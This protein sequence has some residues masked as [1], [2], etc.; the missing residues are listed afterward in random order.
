MQERRRLQ[1]FRLL[2]RRKSLRQ[3]ISDSLHERSA[4]LLVSS[5]KRLLINSSSSL[6]FAGEVAGIAL[7]AMFGSLICCFLSIYGISCI[8]V[9]SDSELF[10]VNQ[11]CAATEPVRWVALARA[12]E[13]SSGYLA[14][15]AYIYGPIIGGIVALIVCIIVAIA[16]SFVQGV[17]GSC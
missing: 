17:S 11:T 3:A 2:L 12:T 5:S 10:S 1:E 8:V 13:S 14:M 16:G 6:S 7:G 9:R 15:A 4:V